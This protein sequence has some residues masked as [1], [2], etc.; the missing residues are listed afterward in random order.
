VRAGA[1]R[2]ALHSSASIHSRGADRD[3]GALR[4]APSRPA[5]LVRQD[6]HEAVPAAPDL[7]KSPSGRLKRFARRIGLLAVV[8]VAI[9]SYRAA[10]PTLIRGKRPTLMPAATAPAPG[11]TSR[12][13]SIVAWDAVDVALFLDSCGTST[14]ADVCQCEVARMP[15]YYAP[16]VALSLA[17]RSGSKGVVLPEN[18]RNVAITCSAG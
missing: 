9:L 11:G 5:G 13:G 16:E 17:D 10:F 18:Y 2:C 6:R 7:P 1:L 3:Q 15:S 8:A 14:P 12:S 4:R